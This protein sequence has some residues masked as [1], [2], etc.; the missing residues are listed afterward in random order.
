MFNIFWR[1]FPGRLSFPSLH[2]Q[3]FEIAFCTKLRFIANYWL[4]IKAN[5]TKVRRFIRIVAN[6]IYNIMSTR[7]S[8]LKLPVSWNYLCIGMYISV[9]SNLINWLILD[10]PFLPITFIITPCTVHEPLQRN[11][12]ELMTRKWQDILFYLPMTW[13]IPLQKVDA[14]GVSNTYR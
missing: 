1:V 14:E 13:I 11:Q 5:K 12:E 6:V 3:T 10:K 7:T 9:K 8:L 2:D 4:Y